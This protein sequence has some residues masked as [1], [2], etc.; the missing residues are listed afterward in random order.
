MTATSCVGSIWRNVSGTPI[1]LL[2]DA[3]VR[4]TRNRAPSAAAVA[5]FAVVFP[6]LP[7]IPTAGIGCASRRAS[8]RRRRAWS[9]SVTSTTSAPSGTPSTGRSTT[10][11][12]APCAKAS[13]TKSCPSR[14]S[15][16][17]KK[18]EPGCAMRESNAP[19]TYRSSGRG[20]PWM[21]RPPVASSRCWRVNTFGRWYGRRL[22]PQAPDRPRSGPLRRKAR[23]PQR[24]DRDPAERGHRGDRSKE[25]RLRP[26]EDDDDD[27]P[28]ILRGDESGEGR[29][30]RV[31][32]VAAVLARDLRGA[33]LP[34]DAVALEHRAVRDPV[35]DRR[36]E[37]PADSRRDVG[38]DDPADRR[39]RGAVLPIR[40]APARHHV[41][42]V[43]GTAVRDRRIGRRELERRRG[44]TLPEGDGPEVDRV[45][46]RERPDAP[47]RLGGEVH[48]GA[49][50]EAERAQIRVH[51]VRAEPA[52][53]E[54][55]A[56]VRRALED[57]PH[58][59][60]PVRLPKRVPQTPPADDR[61]AFVVVRRLWRHHPLVQGRGDRDRLHR[62]ARLVRPRHGAVAERL[63]V[64]GR[65]TGGVVRR[66]RGEREDR[67][68]PRV[69]DDRASAR[70]AL[71]RDRRG[72][73]ALDRGLHREVE[74]EQKVLSSSRIG[75]DAETDGELAVR[76]IA[77]DDEAPVHAAKDRVVPPLDAVLA[78]PVVVHEAKDVRAEG[79]V[80]IEPLRLVLEAE[81]LDAQRGDPLG[82]VF[83]KAP[84]QVEPL[85][86]RVQ[87]GADRLRALS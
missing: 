21:T 71:A 51:V 52:R 77:L 39:R 28:G 41:G 58:P 64:R 75:R 73:L 9:A 6:T 7:V 30:V 47:A 53:D 60:W 54:D 62:G 59:R 3:A 69:E 76:G 25:L 80:R 49:P 29:D 61:E 18:T 81:P 15:R 86:P 38:R 63:G 5:S 4:S 34:R 82:D 33:G 48:T 14:W 10:A 11:A 17:A 35:V 72:E 78:L 65:N 31:V 70:R 57:L 24:I 74:G 84:A 68:V 32:D 40:I 87:R 45:P 66:R 79:A 46:L 20:V 13:T 37:H 83:R 56:R 26:L 2:Y 12:R 1:S 36:D 8:A 16:R 44:E 43:E 42:A 22:C 19:P 85:R 55:R 50:A 27:D 23:V 67:A